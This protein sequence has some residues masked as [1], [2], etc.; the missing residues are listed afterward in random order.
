MSSKWCQNVCKICLLVFLCSMLCLAALLVAASLA[1]K[2]LQVVSSKT[3]V[4]DADIMLAFEI[5]SAD[6]A[7]RTI[8]IDWYPHPVVSCQSAPI[9]VADIYDN[10]EHPSSG[11]EC[12][13]SH[14]IQLRPLTAKLEV[15]FRLIS[16]D[17]SVF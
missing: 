11:S 9:M 5:V 13:T 10:F 1:T 6:S 2:P 3:V 8:T 17:L 4:K 7:A 16:L 15:S 14:P 12:N